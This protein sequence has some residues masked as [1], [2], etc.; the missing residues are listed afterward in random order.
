[1]NGWILG[2]NGAAFWARENGVEYGQRLELGS[3]A[4]S[5]EAYLRLWQSAGPAKNVPCAAGEAQR[6]HHLPPEDL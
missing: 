6:S 3:Q 5:V 1:M 4:M 2:H